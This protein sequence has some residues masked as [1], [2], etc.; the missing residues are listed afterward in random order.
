MSGTLLGTGDRTVR[1]KKKNNKVHQFTELI[2]M[3]KT[4]N[5]ETIKE[6]CNM[7]YVLIAMEK[8]IAGYS[9]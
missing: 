9:R 7:S 4:D 3:G 5:K 6:T 2:L 8:N 1:N